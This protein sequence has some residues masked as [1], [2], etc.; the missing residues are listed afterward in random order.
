MASVKPFRQAR[1]GGPKPEAAPSIADRPPR[2]LLPPWPW[3][4]LA[5]IVAAGASMALPNTYFPGVPMLAGTVNGSF[6]LA[7]KRRV[8]L[9]APVVLVQL[10]IA[11][12]ILPEINV[13]LALLVAML[14]GLLAVPTIFSPR[15]ISPYGRNVM[16][17]AVGYLAISFVLNVALADPDTTFKYARWQGI[18]FLTLVLFASL[19]R[20]KWDVK[21]IGLFV[22]AVGVISSIDAVYQHYNESGAF[23]GEYFPVLDEGRS[24][25]LG[26][27][28]VLFGNQMGSILPPLIGFLTVMYK[29]L[30]DRRTL[31]LGGLCVLLATSIY[32]AQTRSTLLAVGASVAIIALYLGGQRGKVFF[33]LIVVGAIM[34]QG[35]TS[36]GL[37]NSR[38]STT[39]DSSTT[40]HQAL[41][42]AGIAIALDN[43]IIGIGHE[44]FEEV[45]AQYG[46]VETDSSG[47]GKY[48]PH[49]DYLEV[50][51]SWGIFALAGYVGMM[52]FSFKN[53]WIARRSDDLLIRAL[54]MACVGGLARYAVDSGFHNFLD[55]GTF[56]WMFVGL[57]IAL[58]SIA[59]QAPA[60]ATSR[61]PASAVARSGRRAK[62][63][64]REMAGAGA[65]I[66]DDPGTFDAK[67]KYV[68]G[69]VPG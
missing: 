64:A 22:V 8:W 58:A 21:R 42:E 26:D 19:P 23:Y 17:A 12:Y 45:S 41:W 61:V 66:N 1:P 54:T 3:L 40:S 51:T 63:G 55:N 65:Q 60:L 68:Y 4:V 18:Q 5:V 14:T 7:I 31:I 32:L 35:A 52:V 43:P 69:P 56:L 6:V 67:G 2:K 48:R 37:L 36:A 59:Q 27:S 49:N 9:L 62:I 20:D 34:Y 24:V 13:S 44:N 16:I 10:T 11:H 29:G 46:G 47:N 25:G 39:D 53:L 30:K 33:G 38:L 28:P 57:S 15:F 50:W